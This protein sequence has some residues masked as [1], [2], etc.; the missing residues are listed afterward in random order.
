MAGVTLKKILYAVDKNVSH[1]TVS[2]ASQSDLTEITVITIII[3]LS[4]DHSVKML[5]WI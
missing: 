3:K 2:K 4:Q 5:I 1:L